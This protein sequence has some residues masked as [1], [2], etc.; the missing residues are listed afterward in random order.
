M[1]AQGLTHLSVPPQRP[2]QAC[3]GEAAWPRAV[4]QVLLCGTFHA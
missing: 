4:A 1:G 2:A 3:R